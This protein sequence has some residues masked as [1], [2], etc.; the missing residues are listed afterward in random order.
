VGVSFQQPWKRYTLMPLAKGG[1]PTPFFAS[2]VFSS[3]GQVGRLPSMTTLSC[4]TQPIGFDI[5]SDTTTV[6][7]GF[8]NT[9]NCCTE[10]IISCLGNDLLCRKHYLLPS[11]IVRCSKKPLSWPALTRPGLSQGDHCTTRSMSS[12]LT[13]RSLYVRCLVAVRH[14]WYICM[15]MAA[16]ERLQCTLPT[17]T[18]LS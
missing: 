2:C 17:C 4:K 10:L 1:P 3:P 11:F 12:H 5:Q 7:R 8:D 14:S 16:S 18:V 6:F 9:H 15:E 13:T